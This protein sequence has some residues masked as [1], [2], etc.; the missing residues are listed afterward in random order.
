MK[1]LIFEFN[2]SECV[3]ERC[4]YWL[5]RVSESLVHDMMGLMPKSAEVWRVCGSRRVD[6]YGLSS[7]ECVLRYMNPVSQRWVS[8]L[9]VQSVMVWSCDGYELSDRG[10]FIKLKYQSVEYVSFFKTF[11]THNNN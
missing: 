2:I 5:V 10:R 7:V 1:F 9:P 4:R 11:I 8:R 6:E 3:M